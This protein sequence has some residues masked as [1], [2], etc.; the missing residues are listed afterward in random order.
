MTVILLFLGF[1]LC[2]AGLVRGAARVRHWSSRSTVAAA[3]F[4]VS[5]LGCFSAS[6]YVVATFLIVVTFDE[7]KDMNPMITLTWIYSI[8]ATR[9]C[10]V[11]ALLLHSLL[12]LTPA[13]GPKSNSNLA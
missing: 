6:A 2:V 4:W 11:A 5:L 7:T 9:S 12:F 8:N 3:L 1:V 10:S 13:H